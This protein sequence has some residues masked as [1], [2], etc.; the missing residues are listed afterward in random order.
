MQGAV[1]RWL[2]STGCGRFAIGY[3]RFGGL[4]ASVLEQSLCRRAWKSYPRLC[5]R[6]CQSNLF[7]AGCEKV[8]CGFVAKCWCVM[9]GRRSCPICG[10]RRCSDRKGV[11][12]RNWR[13]HRKTA[14]KRSNLG[15]Q[16][17]R[18][19]SFLGYLFYFGRLGTVGVI[20][21]WIG[22][23]GELE[24][25]HKCVKLIQMRQNMGN[26]AMFAA[27]LSVIA[28]NVITIEKC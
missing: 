14:S 15:Q 24:N 28:E 9:V 25:Q 11:N 4:A 3:H 27:N 6:V 22:E 10:N 8:I 7:V 1:I 13:A 21:W 2:A 5:R 18:F 23:C 19:A 17:L 12:R 20:G 16:N 26:K